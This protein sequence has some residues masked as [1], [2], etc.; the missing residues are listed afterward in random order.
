MEG[1]R[2]PATI[3]FAVAKEMGENA[4]SFSAFRPTMRAARKIQKALRDGSVVLKLEVKILGE[5]G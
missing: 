2:H 4:Y 5:I 1:Y 3:M